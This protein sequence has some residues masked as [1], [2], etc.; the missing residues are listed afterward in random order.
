MQPYFS[1]QS[2][3]PFSDPYAQCIVGAYV[4][5]AVNVSNAEDV[6]K[7]IQFCKKYNIRFVIRNTGH[8]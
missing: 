5:Y 8:E 6:S 7:T 1:N 4:Q 2:C 3:D